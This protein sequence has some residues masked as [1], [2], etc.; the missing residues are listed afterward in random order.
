MSMLPSTPQSYS[1]KSTALRRNTYLILFVSWLFLIGTGVLGTMLYTHQMKEKLKA[2]LYTQTEVQLRQIEHNY[3]TQLTEL[4]TGVTQ[5]MKELQGKVDSFNELL[6]FTKDHAS[7]TTD[8]SNKL[9]T[10]LNE[11][12]KK[13]DELKKQLDVLK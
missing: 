7:S 10:Q 13:L 12:K 8:N 5:D 4:K 1:R 3:Q 6:T 2:E 9:Y 11:V